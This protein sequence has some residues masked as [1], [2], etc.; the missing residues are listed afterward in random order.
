MQT[1]LLACLLV[2][3]LTLPTGCRKDAS[4]AEPPPQSTVPPESA[5]GTPARP[6]ASAAPT[7]L[8]VHIRKLAPDGR[9]VNQLNVITPVGEAFTV[10]EQVGA[11]QLALRGKLTPVENGRYRVTYEYVETSADGRPQL[12]STVEMQPDTQQ[13]IGALQGE[14][15]MESVV[16]SLSRP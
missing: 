10:T 12:Q 3:V 9:Q 8:V 13:P 6:S 4:P 14:A 2:V 16:L 11:T 1:I 5:T 7:E 15:G